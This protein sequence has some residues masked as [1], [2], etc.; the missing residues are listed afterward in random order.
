[1]SKRI[2]YFLPLHSTIT[3]PSTNKSY[4]LTKFLGKGAFAQCYATDD[5]LCLKILKRSELTSDRLR[6][7]LSTEICIQRS[8]TH[9]NIVKLHNTFSTDEHI[10]LVMELC[11]ST[12]SDL[13]KQNKRIRES[14]TRTF[15]RQIV[16][17]MAY[18]HSVNVVHRDLK[19]SNILLKNFTVKVADF[20]LCALINNKNK[21]T[22]VCGTPN[23][24]APEI[25]N[26]VAYSF[27]CDLWSLGVMVY[28]ML[29]G[30]P[31][32]QKKTAKEIYNTIKR[33]E[34]KIPENT[35]ISEEAKDLIQRLLITDPHKR[36]SLKEIEKHPFFNKKESLINVV[37][38][39]LRA[40]TVSLVGG[41]HGSHADLS[42]GRSSS[43]PADTVIFC[44]YLSKLNGLGYKMRSN[45]HGIYFCNGDSAI[46]KS[47]TTFVFITASIENNKKV[48]RKEEYAMESIPE[49]YRDYY[50][51]LVYFIRNFYPEEQI[52]EY[53]FTFVVRVRRTKSGYLMG[54]WNNSL[55][56]SV[57]NGV[58]VVWEGKYVECI[59]CEYGSVRDKLIEALE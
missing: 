59:N 49:R 55:V 28:T 13:L 38:N 48:L 20:G 16:S 53:Q 46:R 21:R 47:T 30:T 29:V 5:N 12:L 42:T 6:E 45:R 33:N 52:N 44:I 15:L 25:I 1:M 32:F 14:H 54:L 50:E 39:N 27:E 17:A 24:I 37:L 57:G 36:L 26:K 35:L 9:P 51:R 56:F 40:G 58:V 34:Y 18:L 4:T 7:K 11:D 2:E 10:V 22:T 41:E 3:D 23:Y 19:L 31:P 8:V 43:T